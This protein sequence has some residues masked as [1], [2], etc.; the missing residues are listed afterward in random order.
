MLTILSPAKRMAIGVGP[1]VLGKPQFLSQ[2]HE[3][4]HI[5]QQ[6]EPGPLADLLKTNASL[7]TQAFMDYQD[8]DWTEP[9]TAALF[10]YR[11][12]AY[13]SLAA[14]TLSAQQLDFAQDHVRILSGLYGLLRPLDEI[15]P[16]RLEMGHGLPEIG[17][18]LYR[19]WGS[20]IA[21]ALFAEDDTILNLASVEYSKVV[22]PFV[23]EN[24]RII[25][26]EF[27][28]MHKGRWKIITTAAKQARGWMTGWIIRHQINEPKDI[29]AFD[30]DGYR[31]DRS[32][33]E[34]TIYRFFKD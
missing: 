7:A 34:P 19:Y 29:T 5:L 18:S 28:R 10:A 11:G 12:L 20:K 24:S 33:S 31:F 14:D 3:L 9:G 2:A 1:A 4:V 25:S 23:P 30:M 13:S 15:H 27:Y 22:T 16:Y 21:Q 17:G 8:I 26:C 6:Y 32:R